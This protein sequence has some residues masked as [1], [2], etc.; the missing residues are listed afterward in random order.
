MQ[1]R[2]KKVI[3]YRIIGRKKWKG[4][5]IFSVKCN[6]R[7]R[8]SYLLVATTWNFAM[9]SLGSA[10]DLAHRA[11]KGVFAGYGDLIF[12]THQLCQTELQLVEAF[13]AR[14]Q[15]YVETSVETASLIIEV[16]HLY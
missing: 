12:R 1:C 5:K 10:G 4:V 15:R 6:R 3:R 11:D 8:L 14:P 9:L 7:A 16:A 13:G 2:L